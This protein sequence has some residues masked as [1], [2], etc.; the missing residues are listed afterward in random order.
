MVRSALVFNGD[1]ARTYE[2]SSTR[3]HHSHGGSV[4]NK[5]KLV[6]GRFSATLTTDAVRKEDTGQKSG[7]RS[8]FVFV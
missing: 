2:S 7:E 1:F 8:M 4:K 5:S 3:E 6:N